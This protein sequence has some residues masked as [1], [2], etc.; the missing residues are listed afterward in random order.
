MGPGYTT[1][2][3]GALRVTFTENVFKNIFSLFFSFSFLY[4]VASLAGRFNQFVCMKSLI[5]FMKN[6][7]ILISKCNNLVEKIAKRFYSH[8]RKHNK[9][10]SVSE[11]LE[12]GKCEYCFRPKQQTVNDKNVK[13]TI[14]KYTKTG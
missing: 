9:T 8:W 10:F 7:L 14:S 13:P 3:S 6:L 5:V 1:I 4:A 12:L 11:E 2:I